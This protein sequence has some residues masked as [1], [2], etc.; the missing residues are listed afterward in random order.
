MR[1]PALST[2]K[3]KMNGDLG[4][5]E[6]GDDIDRAVRRVMGIVVEDGV[7]GRMMQPALS[8]AKEKRNVGSPGG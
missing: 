4:E 8:T 7:E 1:Q 5:R 2:A 6:R 3:E